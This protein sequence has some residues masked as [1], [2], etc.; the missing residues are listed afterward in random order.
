VY[1]DCDSCTKHIGCVWIKAART[2][3]TLT[4]TLPIL[5]NTTS[6]RAHNFSNVCW[7]GNGVTGPS[8]RETVGA[9][10]ATIAGRAASR[11]PTAD[12]TSRVE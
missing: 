10:A 3:T 9:R 8:F 5:G 6:V 2:L 12:Q 4:L 11:D 7:A 1:T